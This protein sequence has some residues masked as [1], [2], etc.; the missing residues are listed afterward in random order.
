[1][2]LRERPLF[3]VP[4]TTKQSPKDIIISLVSQLSPEQR[5]QF[6]ALSHH[7]HAI[8]KND[9]IP[10]A[11]FQT[12]AISAGDKV[13]I[14]PK[15]AR[16]NHGCSSAFNVAYSWRNDE[17]VLG[18]TYPLSYI[19]ALTSFRQSRIPSSPSPKGR[20]CSQPIRTL[21]SLVT[22]V[23][24]PCSRHTTSSVN[25]PY[26]PYHLRNLIYRTKD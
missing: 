8:A 13:G 5:D 21:R 12:N 6:N 23:K 26:A 4:P 16:L 2:I 10:L 25:V 18:M 1:M 11:K 24:S 14:F 15:T 7:A 22:S 19:S 3:V 9:E 17:Q 20:N